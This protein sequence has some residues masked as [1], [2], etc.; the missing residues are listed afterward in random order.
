MAV[1]PAFTAITGYSAAEAQGR[2]DSLLKSTHHDAAFYQ[3]MWHSLAET[4]NCGELWNRRKDGSVYPEWL[5]I[6]TVFDEK[7]EPTSYVGVFTNMSRMESEAEM[8]FLAHHDVLTSLPNRLLLLSRIE[9]AVAHG[10]R[11]GRGG[12]VLFI[13]L[14]RFKHVND[15]LGHPVGDE[16]LQKVARRLKS[17]LRES[18]PLARL[19]GDEF[20]VL[21][22]AL[23]SPEDAA[24]VAQLLVDHL[25]TAIELDSR[26]V[27]LLSA[28]I[29]I[30]M[31]PADSRDPHELVR[32]LRR[33]GPL[34]RQGFRTHGHYHFYTEALGQE[35]SRHLA[36]DAACGPAQAEKFTLDY[37]PLVDLCDRRTVGVEALVRWQPRRA[38]GA[39][40]PLHSPRRGNRSHHAP[41]RLGAA[42]GLRPGQSLAQGGLCPGYPGGQS[43]ARAV[44]QSLPGG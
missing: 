7:G 43:L 22:E 38:A 24:S 34:S 12:A 25:R 36:L 31:Y 14:D 23:N 2:G 21:L 33:R 1:N 41:G 29:G 6:S 27:R 44:A 5:T 16:V 40:R 28:S 35:A 37:Q 17:R 39:A 15:S 42:P 8:E 11:S 26:P 32:S 9:H 13:D 4:G 3:A 10:E 30:S 19:G 18:D 20:V